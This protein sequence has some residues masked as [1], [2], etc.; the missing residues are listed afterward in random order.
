MVYTESAHS[1]KYVVLRG[2]NYYQIMF[3]KKWY[4]NLEKTFGC[5]GEK[6][7]IRIGEET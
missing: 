3:T 2:A 4:K 6:S 7:Y 5:F 1:N